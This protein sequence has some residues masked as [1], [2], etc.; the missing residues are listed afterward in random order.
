MKYKTELFIWIPFLLAVTSAY[1]KSIWLVSATVILMFI[2]VAVLPFT[3]KRESL[4]LFIL[5]AVCSVP[6]N[7]FLL[8]EYPQWREVIFNGESGFLNMLSLIEMTLVCTSIEE[9]VV[10]L[11]G[12]RIWKRQYALLLPELEED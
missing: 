1:Y 3:R 4:W 2:M 5:C 7:L 11:I 8:T 10:A 12:R 9:V 6:I